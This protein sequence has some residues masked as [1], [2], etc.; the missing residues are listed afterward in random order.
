MNKKSVTRP[1]NPEKQDSMVT[2]VIEKNVLP[3]LTK[4]PRA[5]NW[6]RADLTRI[7]LD[8]CDEIIGLLQTN[9]NNYLLARRKDALLSPYLFSEEELER[10]ENMPVQRIHLSQLNIDKQHYDDIDIAA[11]TLF[12]QSLYYS[13]VVDGQPSV[14]KVHVFKS[15][16]VPKVDVTAGKVMKKRRKGFIEFQLSVE[17]AKTVFSMENGYVSFISKVRKELK[18]VYSKRIYGYISMFAYDTNPKGPGD[19]KWDISYQDL[20]SML[21]CNEAKSVSEWVPKRNKRYADFKRNVLK[22][23]MEEIRILAGL[24][25]EFKPI[26]GAEVYTDC[27]F[28]FREEDDYCGGDPKSIHFDIYLTELGRKLKTRRI[29]TE[30]SI[31]ILQMLQD[32]LQLHGADSRYFLNLLSEDEYPKFEEEI[33]KIAAS[34]QK[35]SD[36]KEP[37]KDVRAYSVSALKKWFDERTSVAEEVPGTKAKSLSGLDGLWTRFLNEL[38]KKFGRTK[39][40]YTFAN[41]SLKDVKEDGSVILFAKDKQNFVHLIQSEIFK[42]GIPVLKAVFGEN[43]KVMYDWAF[44]SADQNT[45]R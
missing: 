20:R 35:K 44:D 41:I 13:K 40:E 38:E 14:K 30:E 18:S 26:E 9:I 28:K 1:R 37:V 36:S 5:F 42:Q 25:E 7:Q 45:K 32:D 33:H 24:D 8:I 34:I 43:A 17:A 4:Q 15:L 27:Y 22:C 6:L 11:N 16:L 3:S 39:T 23:A 21:G 12:N 2:Y 31:R 29:E 10:D 19:G